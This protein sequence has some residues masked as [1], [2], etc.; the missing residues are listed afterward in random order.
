[1]RNVETLHR[2]VVGFDAWPS[3]ADDASRAPRRLV[4]LVNAASYQ[5]ADVA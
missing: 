2:L 3:D 4:D 1:V 5:Y